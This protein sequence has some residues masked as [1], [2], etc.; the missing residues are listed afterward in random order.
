[1]ASRLTSALSAST[2]ASSMQLRLGRLFRRTLHEARRPHHRIAA[3]RLQAGQAVQQ[4]LLA[5]A[6]IL[7]RLV[8]FANLQHLGVVGTPGGLDAEF[9]SLTLGLKRLYRRQVER[10]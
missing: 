2:L 7:E 6:Q 5:L 10:G 9:K 3:L 8:V 4:A 1:M